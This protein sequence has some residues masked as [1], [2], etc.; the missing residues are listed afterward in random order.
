[1]NMLLLSASRIGADGQA[2]LGIRSRA[3]SA[4]LLNEGF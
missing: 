2:K 3:R 4:P 1:M